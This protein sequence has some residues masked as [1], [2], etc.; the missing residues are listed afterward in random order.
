MKRMKTFAIKT[1]VNGVALWVAALVV[2]GIHLGESAN[3]LSNRLLTIVLVAVIFGLV[4]WVIKPVVKF[5]SIPFILLTLGLF[6]LVINAAMLQL[7]SW[8]AG[9]LNL[10]FHVDNF[11]W[12]AVLGAIIITLVSV[13]L[14]VLLPDGE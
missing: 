10:D 1:I 9:G 7:T 14:N 8:V 3:A 5:F 4:N 6:T 12:D 2:Q 13:V 11:F